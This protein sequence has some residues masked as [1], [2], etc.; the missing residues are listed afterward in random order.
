MPIN[1]LAIKVTAF[2]EFN[3]LY[4]TMKCSKNSTKIAIKAPKMADFLQKISE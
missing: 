4:T 1:F 2:T 3:N